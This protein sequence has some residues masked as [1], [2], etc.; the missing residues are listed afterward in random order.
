MKYGNVL[1]RGCIWLIFISTLIRKYFIWMM[2]DGFYYGLQ[3]EVQY[4]THFISLNKHRQINFKRDKNFY[5]YRK[6]FK[7][8]QLS[9]IKSY[10]F[11]SLVHILPQNES[12]WRVSTVPK[13]HK[14]NYALRVTHHTL[15][16]T[17]SQW[18]FLQ[19]F[20]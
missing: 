14:E 10:W 9:Y 2:F 3:K 20:Y 1:I 18:M 16:T 4:G 8:T 6:F 13:K 19:P 12:N 7:F 5:R 15:N 17:K 11:I